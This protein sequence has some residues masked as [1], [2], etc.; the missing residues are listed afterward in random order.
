MYD[1]LTDV[2]IVAARHLELARK[3]QTRLCELE[4]DASRVACGARFQWE[5][6]T[7]SRSIPAQGAGTPSKGGG[8]RHQD[9]VQQLLRGGEPTAQGLSN[10]ITRRVAA[11]VMA[12][13]QNAREKTP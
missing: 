11:D 12:Y 8:L 6:G 2:G 4:C 5:F 1:L 10:A 7:I 3:E 13:V 9:C